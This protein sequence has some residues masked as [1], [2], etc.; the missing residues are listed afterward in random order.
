MKNLNPNP[1][2]NLTPELAQATETIQRLEAEILKIK[3]EYV[4]TSLDCFNEALRG[5]YETIAKLRSQLSNK[6]E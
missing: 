4:Q 5:E 3:S 1:N 2:T 6:D